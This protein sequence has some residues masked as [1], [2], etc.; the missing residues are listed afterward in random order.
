MMASGC[1]VIAHNSGG[2]KMD[3]VVPSSG[4]TSVGFL[5]NDVETYSDALMEC[6][7]MKE[8]ARVALCNRARQSLSRFSN[9]A[10]DGLVAQKLK[11]F[12]II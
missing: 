12:E 9:E 10:F 11:H 6:L 7:L 4:E 3:I 5:A 2:P 1:L 8:G